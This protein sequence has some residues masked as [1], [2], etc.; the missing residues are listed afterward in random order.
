M[1]IDEG[2]QVGGDELIDDKDHDDGDTSDDGNGQRGKVQPVP[3]FELGGHPVDEHSYDEDKHY[4]CILCDDLWDDVP[5]PWGADLCYHLRCSEPRLM[6][7]CSGVEI[8]SCTEEQSCEGDKSEGL[9][10]SP[11]GS[12]ELYRS[13]VGLCFAVVEQE[14]DVPN[15]SGKGNAEEPYG[16]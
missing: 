15:G 12:D 1:E 4:P 9:Q 14:V 7:G 16:A 13:A 11:E 10:D 2:L 5:V 3:L 6:V 8:A